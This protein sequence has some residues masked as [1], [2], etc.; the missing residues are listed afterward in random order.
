MGPFDFEI[1][2]IKNPPSFKPSSPYAN[3]IHKTSDTFSVQTVP[4][5]SPF[6]IQNENVSRIWDFEIQQDS[7]AYGSR[8]PVQIRF[9]TNNQISANG[10]VTLNWDSNQLIVLP[11]TQCSLTT[12]K[13]FDSS[14]CS[15]DLQNNELNI[16]GA[17]EQV[18]SYLG[19]II[20]DLDQVEVP[21]TNQI[22]KPM[23]VKTFD[24]VAKNY[25]I[26]MLE[27]DPV[28]QCFYPCKFCAGGDR[29][30]DCSACWLNPEEPNQKLM[31]KG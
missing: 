25:P 7:E 11:E 3:I 31:P 16:Y 4:D 21:E 28:L 9:E 20:I 26:D 1:H 23:I 12:Y 24:D 18:P 10:V 5:Y 13:K 27:V 14:F 2:G 8:T 29:K 17:F 30:D 19:T 15:W 6:F 22:L